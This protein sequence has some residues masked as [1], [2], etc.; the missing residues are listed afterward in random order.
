[1]PR[2]ASRTTS[3]CSWS[4]RRDTTVVLHVDDAV[5]LPGPGLIAGTK[6]IEAKHDAITAFVAATLRA[7]NEIK[8]NPAVGL[9]AAIKEVPE[10]AADRAGQ[11]A[12]LDG[13][14]RLVDG[15]APGDAR[16]RRDRRGGLDVVDP[17]HER[18]EAAEEAGR[19]QGLVQTDLLPP[20]D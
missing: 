10:L 7:M 3:R 5:P 4:R 16:S 19:D 12:V 20:A 1:M 14:G 17:R 2:P 6:T 15:P 9:D 18:P 13:D 11:A 8:A